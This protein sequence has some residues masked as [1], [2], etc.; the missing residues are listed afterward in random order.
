MARDRMGVPEQALQ[1]PVHS[2]SRS[3]P[4]QE[5]LVSN[6]AETQERTGFPGTVVEMRVLIQEERYR[7]SVK[8]KYSMPKRVH[9]L[10]PRRA[11]IC[12]K[13]RKDFGFGMG[14]TDGNRWCFGNGI[15]PRNQKF[16]TQQHEKGQGIRVTT[17]GNAKVVRGVR[18]IGEQR[19]S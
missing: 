5:L 1:T 4:H 10:K 17:K 18:R 15:G 14:P 9:Y 7:N 6:E 11:G 8:Y 19:Q 2:I 12:G 13:R 3:Q 16:P